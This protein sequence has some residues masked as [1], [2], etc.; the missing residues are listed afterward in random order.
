MRPRLPAR[1][2]IEAVLAASSAGALVTT[3]LWRSWIETV[4]AID[5]D[6]HSGAL[7]W[8]ITLALAAITVAF[9]VPA[10]A[11]IPGSAREGGS[12]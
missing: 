6:H 8:A 4:F 10:A 9:A 7:E 3:L 1:F 11:H 2:W 5:P 12:S